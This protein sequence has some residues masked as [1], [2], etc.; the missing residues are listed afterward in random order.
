MLNNDPDWDPALFAGETRLYYGR[1]T[2]KYESAARQGAAGAIIIHTTPSAGYPWQVVQASW[3]GE[4][5]ELPAGDEPRLQVRAWL[6]EDKAR[7]L[8]KLAGKDLELL[9]EAAKG[10]DFQPVPLGVTTSLTMPVKKESTHSANV[11]GLLRGSDPVLAQQVVIYTAHHD[12]FGIGNPDETGDRIY[13]GARD[14]ASGVGMV[15]GIAKAF[16]ALPQPPRRSILILLVA[17]EEQGLLG[18]KYYAAHPTFAPGRIAADINF[19]SGNIWGETHDVTYIGLGKSSLDAVVRQAVQHQGR[20]L[21]G[22]EFP[23]RGHFYRSDQFSLAHI[24]V[25]ALYL[26]PGTEVV[27]QPEGWGRAQQEEY[28]LK[29]YHQ[30]SDEYDDSWNLDGLVQ[31]AKLGYWCGLIVANAE[32]MPAWN[33]GD[34]FEAARKEALQAAH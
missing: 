15:L 7:E 11:I 20:V 3:S 6:T 16:K 31:D 5:F 29:R 32:Q 9:R 27:G 4:Q 13:N 24:G 18:S 14:N 33:P 2:Y 25:P 8:V 34:E 22:D 28:T 19:D 12:H 30:P 17:G 21:K 23:D 1:W 10:R 26:N